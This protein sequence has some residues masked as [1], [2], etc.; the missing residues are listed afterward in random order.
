M[1]TIYILVDCYK[2]HDK[3]LDILVKEKL[4]EIIP[5]QFKRFIN[6]DGA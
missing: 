5:R 2:T 4:P 1:S 3:A 6:L